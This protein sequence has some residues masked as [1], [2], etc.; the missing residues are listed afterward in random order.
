MSYTRINALG[1][2]GGKILVNLKNLDVGKIS[3]IN[4]KYQSA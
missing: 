2:T 4:T 1:V 3:L